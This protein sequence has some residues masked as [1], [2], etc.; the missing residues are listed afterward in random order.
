MGSRLRRGGIA[1]FLAFLVVFGIVGTA[2]LAYAAT[3]PSGFSAYPGTTT[4]TTIKVGIPHPIQF[5]KIQYDSP[6]ADTGKNSSLNGEW[7]AIHNSGTT[8]K[9]LKGFTVRDAQNHVYKFATNF[10]LKPSKSVKIHTG[11][12]TNTST[13]RYWGKTTYVWGNS[14]DKATLKNSSGTTLDTC[15]WSSHGLGYKQC[16]T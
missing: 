9:N 7:A 1:T 5:G 11:K 6:G 12:G 10:N 15:S 3:S 2:V 13:D 16:P 14:S 8:T 4:T